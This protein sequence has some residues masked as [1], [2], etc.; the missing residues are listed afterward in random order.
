MDR[1]GEESQREKLK[2][3]LVE[4]ARRPL[5]TYIKQKIRI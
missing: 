5:K 4:A 3:E 2:E 1:R